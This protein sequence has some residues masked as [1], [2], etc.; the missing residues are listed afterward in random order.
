MWTRHTM[1]KTH[2]TS[3]RRYQA[4]LSLLCCF[5]TDLV[6]VKRRRRA[7]N[8][9]LLSMTTRSDDMNRSHLCIFAF[10]GWAPD[11][12]TVRDTRVQ[13]SLDPTPSSRRAILVNLAIA[14]EVAF[15]PPGRA[16]AQMRRHAHRTLE[17]GKVDREQ[18]NRDSTKSWRAEQSQKL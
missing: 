15:M 4:V 17:A 2:T 12:T 14:L 1:R 16:A 13:W 11:S 8:P 5:A 10:L 9:L 18:I 7:I 6:F 3:C